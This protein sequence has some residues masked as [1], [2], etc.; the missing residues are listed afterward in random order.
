M[1]R[2]IFRS[3]VV[4]L[5]LTLV[6][7]LGQSSLWQD[8]NPYRDN[9]EPGQMLE[10]KVDE[11]FH[12]NIDSQ[13][14]TNTRIQLQLLPDTKNLPFLSSSEQSKTKDSQS[15]ARYRIRDRLAFSM[16]AIVGASQQNNIYPIQARKTLVIDGKPT[17][18]TLTGFIDPK[19]V[20]NDMVSSRHVADLN[21]SVRTEPPPVLDNSIQLK[22]PRPEEITDPEN[23][24]PDKAELSEAEK[25]AILLNHL[26][27]I[28]GILSR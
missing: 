12:I 9:I 2:F 10:V 27:E 25:Q 13:W 18:I 20:K 17:R 1:V 6:S 7:I 19:Y 11:V 28:I 26:R 5:T 21:L 3:V 24:P 15:K 23:P 16:Q 4:L 14:D 22:P 8:R